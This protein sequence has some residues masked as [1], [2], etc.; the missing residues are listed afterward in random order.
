P[1]ISSALHSASPSRTRSQEISLTEP[2]PDKADALVSSDPPTRRRS[3]GFCRSCETV[4]APST[5]PDSLNDG[6]QSDE[7]PARRAPARDLDMTRRSR[8]T[9]DEDAPS[10]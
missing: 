10:A 2:D 7:R 4:R 1:T 6:A 8:Y 9:L 5:Y 3:S